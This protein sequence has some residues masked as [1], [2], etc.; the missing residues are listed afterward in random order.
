MIYEAV[1][2]M[3]T[4]LSLS[5][6]T[7]PPISGRGS[8]LPLAIVLYLLTVAPIWVKWLRAG[9]SR[10]QG[11]RKYG[12]SMTP[13]RKLRAYICMVGKASN[14]EK[15]ETQHAHNDDVWQGILPAKIMKTFGK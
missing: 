3:S 14:T 7:I 5:L 1:S 4:C 12:E 10:G 11:S 2:F 8:S 9:T 13:W 6:H 15:K